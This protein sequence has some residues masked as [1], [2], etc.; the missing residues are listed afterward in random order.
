MQEPNRAEQQYHIGIKHLSRGKA[1][2]AEACFRAALSDR[3][4][5]AE[6]ANNL[7]VA[8]GN[9]NQHS[10]A[11]DCFRRAVQLMP[12]FADARHNLGNGLRR[13]G[14]AEEALEH[15]REAIRLKAGVADVHNNFG[16]AL[17]SLG[18]LDDAL[19]QFRQALRVKPRLNEAR[20]NLGVGLTD[21]GLLAEAVA[22]YRQV[23]RDRPNSAETQNNLG[24]V[25][26]QQG[27][28]EEAVACYR[29]ALELRPKYADARNNLGNALRQ[30]GRFEDA[31]ASLREALQLKPDYAE[32]YNNLAI[33]LVKQE[34]MDEAVANYRQA[35]QLKPD[36]P[37]ARKNLGLAFLGMGELS[38]GWKEYEWRWNTKELPA[39]KFAQPRWD[40]RPL[41]GKTILLYAEQGMGDTIQFIRYV[42][43]VEQRGGRVI[44]E[45]QKALLG[46]LGRCPAI[47]RLIP[48]GET[49][50]DFDVQAPLMSL[51]FIFDTNLESIPN[52]GSYL[53]ADPD[54]LRKW[55]QELKGMTGFKI[56]IAWQGS[57]KY[58]DDKFRSIR[59]VNYEELARIP[60]VRLISLQKGFGA[61]QLNE[62]KSWNV[63]D[64]GK[65]LDDKGGFLD[66]AAIMKQLDLVV[67]SDTAI[68]HLAGALGVPV[69][70]ATSMAPD[71]RW[72]LQREDNPWYPT[73]R[74]FRQTKR[75]DWRDV[76]ERIAHELEMRPP[77]ENA[78]RHA[79]KGL[80]LLQQ[81]KPA[82]AI[83]V[84]QRALDLDPKNAVL[85]N[86][87]AVALDK[88]GKKNEALASFQEAVRLKPDYSDALH[89]LGNHLRRM[90]RH[91]E[92]EAEY[93]KALKLIPNSPDLCNHM[94]ITLL[95]QAKHGE[96]EACFR[97][98][99]RLKPDHPEAHN[100]L[101][102][103][104]EQTG[105][106]DQAT[107]CYQES[108]RLKADS[109]DTHKNL[110]LSWLMQGEFSRGWAEYEWRW[111]CTPSPARP[112]EQ[113]RWDGRPL[114]GKTIL[115]YS[116]QGLGDTIQFIRYASLVQERGGVVLV[117]C[118]GILEKLLARCPGID[119]VIPQGTPLPD[120]SYQIPFLSVPG[121]FHT[122]LESVPA[123]V[124]Y[125]SA[126]P[127]LIETWGKELEC[128][129]GFKIG[130]AWQGSQKYG[131]D[132]HRSI[133]LKQFEPLA[134]M[135]GVQLVSLQKGFG[136][137]QLKELGKQWNVVDFGERLD[138]NGAFVDTA[139][140][141]TCVDLVVTSDTAVAHLAGALGVP[142][143]MALSTASDWRWLRGRVDCPWY[144]TMRLFRQA[145][146]GDWE[147]VFCRIAQ[148]L[149]N[150]RLSL[151]APVL[152]EI[153]PGELLDK[154]TIL[155]IK[156]S[157]TQDEKKLQNIR[158]ELGALL[159]V[160]AR[161]LK[162]L[163]ELDRLT[164]ELKAVN[165]KLWDIE[166]NIRVQERD[167]DFG[168][169]FVE[170]ARSVYHCNDQR[171]ALKR[172]VN[173][174]LGS[175]I[176]E[177]KSYASYQPQTTGVQA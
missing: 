26:V 119:R 16:L 84:L 82:E 50:P 107:A 112:F 133:P 173:E 40:G 85:R 135:P 33:V 65:R 113:P 157:R 88:E 79:Q 19:A 25:L 35:L 32:A 10:E 6:A 137:E 106:L 3:P 54:R 89:N 102:V 177:E 96:A 143:W 45:C 21:K 125:L 95:A 116:E 39:R 132:A 111:K 12:D 68:A 22:A 141:M 147:G 151:R 58:Q 57:P 11:L 108:L 2:E 169:R 114:E 165:E 94:G 146:W 29:R 8:L 145:G 14:K 46:L 5:W 168:P 115:L 78:E 172:K 83:V 34:R 41:N 75:G 160:R 60:G 118:P 52:T 71:W 122:T 150:S 124:P 162:P 159:A 163:R 152:A 176:V 98:G 43:L 4:D 103:L 47:F 87:L 31:E 18:R 23:L 99:L 55:G 81:G 64:F 30:L 61:E 110:A 167:Q 48:H 92:A 144:P 73:M 129:A 153:A 53:T 120:F 36:Y 66:T 175:C 38:D 27:K 86:N 171:A 49:L 9:R 155:E 28:L 126:D 51:P 161:S 117:E 130:I 138:A 101:G 20:N 131:G 93:R 149:S 158:V 104:L 24:V 170:L 134:K 140:I 148:E 1:A 15:Y 121:A 80:A 97:R 105:K 56:G 109:P 156:R 67:T 90:G 37:D 166:D 142:V 77:L 76:F 91:P 164:V 13:A 72:L 44:V 123:A 63:V 69:W 7:G 42:S 139:A 62:V 136:S 74:L 17:R 127:R 174:L 128:A 154:I 100:N 59:L 70:M